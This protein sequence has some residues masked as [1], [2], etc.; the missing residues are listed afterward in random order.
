MTSPVN[1]LKR[2]L[3]DALLYLIVPGRS[4][5]GLDDLLARVL[6]A[7]VDMVQLREK[8]PAASILESAEIVRRR[9]DEFDALFIVNDDVDAA[10]ACGA[11]GV[12]LG[13]EDLDTD[14]AR[15]RLGRYL[16]IGQSTHSEAE[17]ERA[18]ASEADYVGVG[19]VY[20]TPTKPGR[21]PVGTALLRVAAERSSLPF[22]AIGGIDENV[23]PAVI[24]AGASRVSV[25]RAI[26]D[27]QDPAAVAKRMK[28]ALQKNQ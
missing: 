11:D 13:Q 2:R 1:P 17:I 7:G 14:E 16:L 21:P 4:A 24:Q 6:E 5:P 26:L 10:L 9:T 20:S 15:R 18:A 3:Q 27:A 8:D 22:F 28:E 19:P 12:H 25:L 23:L